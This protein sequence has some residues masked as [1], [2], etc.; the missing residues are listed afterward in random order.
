M[1]KKFKL[2]TDCT[3][4]KGTLGFLVT[5][6]NK[7]KY[8]LVIIDGFTKFRLY[9]TNSKE[10]I[11]CLKDYCRYYGKPRRIVSKRGTA[12]IQINLL[13]ELKRENRSIATRS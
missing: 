9:V 7:N 1:G 6:E 10:V 11:K 12:S 2:V 13:I 4:L 8:I 3:A 5:T